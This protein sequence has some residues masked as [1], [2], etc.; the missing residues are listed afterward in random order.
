MNKPGELS[1]PYST[2][3][4]T[5]DAVH[6]TGSAM[7]WGAILAGATA[8]ASLSLILLLLGVGLGL[9]SVSPWA[10]SGISATTLGTSTILWLTVTQLLASGLGGY[11]AGRLRDSWVD[12]NT[13]EVY[14]RDTAHGFLAWA[15]A[16]LVTASLLASAVGAVVSG[17]A[18]AGAALTNGMASTVMTTTLGASAPLGAVATR[19][20]G[21]SGAL[22]YFVDSL[23]RK[24]GNAALEAGVTNSNGVPS[25][26]GLEPTAAT[27]SYEVTRILMT[28]LQAGSLAP[29]DL[30]YV[31]QVVAL[32]TGLN[33]QEAEKRVG[34]T[35]AR[36]QAALVAAE[37]TAREAADQ[38][39]KASANATLWLFISL[40]VGAFV[41]SLA[42]TYGGRQRDH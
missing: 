10:S 3:V 20:G 23:F 17:G 4:D 19:S 14:F 26:P 34:E 41:A 2:P 11:L 38:A 13:D 6:L 7:S 15:I 35:F 37:T 8:A 21:E 36:L 39:R 42:A 31:G 22:P 1:V 28:A 16:S 40:L 25:T 9:S 12:I 30:N 32:R 33:Q 5:L 29:E 18:Q 27:S 24:D